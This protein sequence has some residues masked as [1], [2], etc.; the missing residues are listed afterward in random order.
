MDRN[1]QESRR[2]FQGLAFPVVVRS[3]TAAVLVAVGQVT[4]AAMQL[5]SEAAGMRLEG[6]RTP[7]VAVAEQPQTWA[8][9]SLTTKPT[10]PAQRSARLRV[11]R[12][13]W[14]SGRLEKGRL[15]R[16]HLFSFRQDIDK[17]EKNF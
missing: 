13:G 11:R 7:T 5:L 4:P 10:P 16:K 3:K 17:L 12:C 8:D 1:S 9:L 2:R 14:R 6:Q 15:C